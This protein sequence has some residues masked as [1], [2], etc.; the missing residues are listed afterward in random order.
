MDYSSEERIEWQRRLQK[1]QEAL[2]NDK[3]K[4][5]DHLADGLEESLSKVRYKNGEVE[6]DTVD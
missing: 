6:L 2:E 5:V 4:V 3:I 1:L